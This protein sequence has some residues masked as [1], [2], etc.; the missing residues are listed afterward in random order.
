MQAERWKLIE[1]LYQAAVAQ[2][3]EKRAAFLAS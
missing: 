1:E 3:D 2:P